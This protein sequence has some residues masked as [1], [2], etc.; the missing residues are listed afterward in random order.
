MK[1]PADIFTLQKRNSTSTSAALDAALLG[2]SRSRGVPKGGCS[3]ESA[4]R[5]YRGTKSG[6]D[7]QYPEGLGWDAYTASRS[8]P[9]VQAAFAKWRACM[10]QRGYDLDDPVSGG[11]TLFSKDNQPPPNKV[12]VPHPSEQEVATARADVACKRTVHLVEV[13]SEAEAALQVKAIAKHRAQLDSSD[14][15]RDRVLRNARS[16]L[17]R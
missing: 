16:V 7:M 15:L 2:T 12:F 4:R 17:G 13:W 6:A 14:A 10:S 11:A 3:G 5:L 1:E 8:K 9:L